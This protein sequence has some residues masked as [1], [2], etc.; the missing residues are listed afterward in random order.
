MV[1]FR[2]LRDGGAERCE[3]RRFGV[4]CHHLVVVCLADIIKQTFQPMNLLIP[5]FQ[6]T[7]HLP[8]TPRC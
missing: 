4:C 8:A 3:S 7:L 5:L 2:S 1:G 6:L